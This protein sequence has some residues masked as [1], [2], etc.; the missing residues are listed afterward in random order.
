MA[1]CNNTF[2]LDEYKK[3]DLPLITDINNKYNGPLVGIYSAMSWY[4]EQNASA[5][6]LACFPA[7]VPIFPTDVVFKLKQALE[8]NQQAETSGDRNCAKVAW[9]QTGQQIQPLFSLW[10]FELLS[11]L[12]QSIREGIYGPKLFFEQHPNIRI[13]L[14]EPE[15]GMFLNINTPGDLVLAESLL[16]GADIQEPI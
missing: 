16:T 4:N 6:F 5:E 8:I 7:D 1:Y 13:Q 12:E 14:P 15:N 9:C 2:R 3:Y 10:S 11:A